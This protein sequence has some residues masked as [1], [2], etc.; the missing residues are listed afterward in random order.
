MCPSLCVSGH[1]LSFLAHTA[2]LSSLTESLRLFVSLP[3][4]FFS[5]PVSESSP[6]PSSPLCPLLLPSFSPSP[7]RLSFPPS[8]H[9]ALAPALRLGP[10]A[11]SQ[12]SLSEEP[13]P[14]QLG[15]EQLDPWGLSRCMTSGAGLPHLGLSSELCTT[16]QTVIKTS[17]GAGQG[18]HSLAVWLSSLLIR[19]P[20]PLNEF[21]AGDRIPTDAQEIMVSQGCPDQR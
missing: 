14:E 16:S 1:S 2:P 15:Q 13:S 10:S 11:L 12:G 3:F 21:S 19:T 20:P 9:R 5:L 17:L 4:W 18:Y 6:A 7:A 8:A